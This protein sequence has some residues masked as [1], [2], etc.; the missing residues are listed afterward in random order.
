M[1]YT[2]YAG[3]QRISEINAA[4]KLL[5]HL[6]ARSYV[7]ELEVDELVLFVYAKEK[8]QRLSTK[9]HTPAEHN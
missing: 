5:T 1:V 4:K 2:C 8:Q 7:S 6:R 9:I 3:I